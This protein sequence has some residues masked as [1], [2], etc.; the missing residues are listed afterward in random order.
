MDENFDEGQSLK[1]F[2]HSYLLFNYK[3]K[4]AILQWGGLGHTT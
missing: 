2:P 4:V 1:A 3:K